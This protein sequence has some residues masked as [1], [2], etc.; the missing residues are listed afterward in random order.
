[1]YNEHLLS[2]QGQSLRVYIVFVPLMWHPTYIV[3]LQNP[4]DNKENVEVMTNAPTKHIVFRT[5]QKANKTPRMLIQRRYLAAMDHHPSINTSSIYFNQR[6]T[7]GGNFAPL[8]IWQ[9]LEVLLVVT[10]RGC[11]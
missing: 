8:D 6:F 2:S 9:T 11:C 10:T 7:T 5:T 1:M 3:G 4:S